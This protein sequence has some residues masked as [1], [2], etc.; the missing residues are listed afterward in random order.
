[1]ILKRKMEKKTAEI[2]IGQ[3]IKGKS[4]KVIFV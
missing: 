1:M 2:S 3:V 4:S